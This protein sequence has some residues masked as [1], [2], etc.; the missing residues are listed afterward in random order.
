M[1]IRGIL[2]ALGLLLY[3]NTFTHDYAQDDAIVIYDNMFVQDG[4][5]GIP[6]LLSK[7]TFF[8]FFKVEGKAKLVSGGRYRPLTPIMFAIEYQIFGDNPFIGHFINAILYGL[9]VLVIFNTLFK[10]LSIEEFRKKAL[11]ISLMAAVIFAVHPVHTEAVANIKG[12]DEIVALLASMYSLFLILRYT[13]VGKKKDL[14]MAALV[15]FLGLLSKENTITFLAVIPLALILFRG[16]SVLDSVIGVL[17]LI[18]SSVIF[19]GIRTAVLGMDFGGTPMELMNNPFLKI[20]NNAYVPFNASEKMA[21]ITYTMGKYVSLLFLPHPLTH[22]YYPRH[23]DLMSWSDISVLLTVLMYMVMIIGSIVYFKKHKLISFSIWFFLIT[24]SIVSNIV[25]PIGTNMS[26]RFLFM[27]SVGFALGLAALMYKIPPKGK[28]ILFAIVVLGMATKTVVRNQVW[29][30]DF[31]LFTTDVHTSKRSAKLLNAAGG[32]L[33]T[34]ARALPEGKKRTDMLIKA[35]GYL[36][37]AVKIHPNYKNA[38]LLLGNT[39]YYL[40][41]YES[42]IQYYDQALR[43]A[44]NYAEAQKN[45]GITLRDAGRHYGEVKQDLTTAKRFLDRSYSINK[46]DYETVRLL[47]IVSGMS[48]NN[49]QAIKYFAEAVKL[50][51]ELAQSYSNLGTAYR[52]AGDE[53]KANENFQKALQL[54]PNA[55]NHLRQ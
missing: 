28:W 18:I 50:Q 11:P 49:S 44:P 39:N 6:G 7:D 1:K 25:F 32:A 10:L 3:A 33:S 9:L 35:D 48:G 53:A 26:E 22:D 27:P 31:T 46:T 40:K 16:K 36:K 43:V 21:T 41:R 24:M 19:I 14:M 42:A 20:E 38:Y 47:G 29:K 54:D 15:F 4:V 51:P 13:D 2:F 5:A 34:E 37:E 17:P 45:L 52:N 55:L 8:G 23:V 30:D 12:R